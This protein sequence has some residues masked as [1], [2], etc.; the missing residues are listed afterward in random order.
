MGES[1][2]ATELRRQS[3][4]EEAAEA[5]AAAVAPVPV[6]AL[7]RAAAEPAVAKRTATCFPN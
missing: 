7:A 3:T 2:R 1:I 5:F 4:P 6:P